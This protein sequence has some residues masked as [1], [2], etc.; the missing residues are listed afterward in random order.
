[1]KMESFGEYWEERR[2]ERGNGELSVFC[3]RFPRNRADTSDSRA[4]TGYMYE[5]LAVPPHPSPWFVVCRKNRCEQIEPV[6][7]TWEK[8]KGGV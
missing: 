5:F 6:V 7:R 3:S 2:R 4:N 1:M 8:R